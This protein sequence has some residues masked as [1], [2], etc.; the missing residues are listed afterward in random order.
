LLHPR[1]GARA[2]RPALGRGG[3]IEQLTDAGLDP[4]RRHL[5]VRRV[6]IVAGD[7]E[8]QPAVV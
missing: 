2:A 8:V 4:T 3:G 7:A 6:L 1:A 5:D